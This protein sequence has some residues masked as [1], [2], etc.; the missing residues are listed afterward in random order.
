MSAT[1]TNVDQTLLFVLTV[2]CLG[3]CF[4]WAFWELEQARLTI[5]PNA[6]LAVLRVSRGKSALLGAGTAVTRNAQR[7]R[8]PGRGNP[9]GASFLSV[10][11][12]TATKPF[13]EFQDTRRKRFAAIIPATQSRVTNRRSQMTA[14]VQAFSR[15]SFAKIE[16]ET[17]R[18]LL[19]FCGAGLFVSLLLAT[20]GLDMSP[21]FF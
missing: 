21:G 4:V 17:L 7:T 11:H 5:R 18:A 20:Y 6:G 3:A 14:L 12:E 1:F 15:L 8:T 2:L 9:I 19:M 16:T 13:P 10:P